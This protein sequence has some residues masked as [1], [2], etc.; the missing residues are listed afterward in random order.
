VPSFKRRRPSREPI[1]TEPK[2]SRKRDQ[3]VAKR[4][5]RTW[6]RLQILCPDPDSQH[7]LAWLQQQFGKKQRGSMESAQAELDIATLLAN[8]G[9]TLSFVKESET[10]TADLECYLG[11]DRVFVEVTVIVPTDPD[12]PKGV[13]SPHGLTTEEE[14]WDFFKD[15]LVKRLLGRINEKANQLADYCAPVVLAITMVHQEQKPQSNGKSN[16]RKMAL[17]LQQLGGV[18]THA[19][20]K[21]PQVSAVILTLWNIQPAESRSS[22]RFSN[23]S[24]G[25]WV[26]E[27]KGFSQIRF[28]AVNPVSSYPIEPEAC[29]ALRRVL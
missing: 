20:G 28:F 17:D 9:F 24:V 4:F 25:E 15:A 13:G 29:L 11:N 26:L 14:D 21:A 18:T 16:G 7:R 2:V 22:I 8:A 19:L 23:V 3:S 10:A 5:D 27:P 12:R 1:P 6:R